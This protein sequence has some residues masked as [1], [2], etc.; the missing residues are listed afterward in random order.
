M[1]ERAAAGHK[2]GPGQTSPRADAAPSGPGAPPYR[3]TVAGMFIQLAAFLASHHHEHWADVLATAGPHRL[4]HIYTWAIHHGFRY[5]P[6]AA[7]ARL[8]P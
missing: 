3:S 5:H 1:G 6:S 8:L 4:A 7:A 2:G